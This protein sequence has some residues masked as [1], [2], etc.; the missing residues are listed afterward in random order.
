MKDIFLDRDG[1]INCNRTDHVKSWEEFQFLP[2]SLEAIT[3]LTRASYRI[4]VITNQAVINRGLLAP[5][6]LDQIHQQMLAEVTAVGGKIEAILYC[7]H[8]PEE[9]CFCR[10]PK[11]GLLQK[12]QQ[13]YKAQA[14]NSWLVGDHPNDIVAGEQVGCRN[15]LVLSGRSTKEDDFIVKRPHMPIAANLAAAAKI[16]LESDN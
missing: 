3:D 12:A 11:P 7:P 9:N 14:T 1:V 5:E 6:K 8:R 4:F 16:I 13:L 10:K 2:G 15:I